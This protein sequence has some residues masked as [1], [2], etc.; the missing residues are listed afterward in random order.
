MTEAPAT[1]ETAGVRVPL[2][3]HFR[4]PSQQ[5][6]A[7]VLGMWMFL[8]TEV[9]L[10]GA[11]FLGYVV[12]RSKPDIHLGFVAASEKLGQSVF[13]FEHVPFLGALNTVVLLGSSFTM[14]L[15]V[16]AAQLGHTAALVRNLG[17]TLI[18]GTFFLGIKAYEYHHDWEV[19]LIPGFK[20]DHARWDGTGINSKHVELFFVFYFVLTGL[21]A[22]HMVVGMSILGVLWV[23]S[24]MG[25]FGAAYYTP[26]EL[27]GLYWHFVD[28]VWIFLYPLLYLI[29][30]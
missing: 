3:H 21:H 28:V 12:Y 26:I 2:A 24:R 23:R 30:H 27:A 25:R 6:N 15:A 19:G 8:I 1:G 14:A 17:L 9:L 22:I 29:R 18:L 5:H 4:T 16:R 20:F 13:G 11:V 10:F 7:A